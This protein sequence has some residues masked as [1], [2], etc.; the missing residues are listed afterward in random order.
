MT[1]QEV[2]AEIPRLTVQERLALIEALKRSVQ[3]ELAPPPGQQMLRAEPARDTAAFARLYG[4]L[5]SKGE[6]PT[7]ADVR[8]MITD[9]LIE[10]HS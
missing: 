9:Q 8:D 4:V 6:A 2:V 10:K 3:Q 1:Y 5:K 7:D